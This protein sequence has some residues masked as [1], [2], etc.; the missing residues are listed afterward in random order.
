MAGIITYA[1]EKNSGLTAA[2]KNS[3]WYHPVLLFNEIGK[4]GNFTKPLRYKI[5]KTDVQILFHGYFQVSHLTVDQELKKRWRKIIRQVEKGQEPICYETDLIFL[6][7][8]YYCL[9]AKTNNESGKRVRIRRFIPWPQSKDKVLA[10]AIEMLKNRHDRG[11]YFLG[12][13]V[14]L[15]VPTGNSYSYL[16]EQEMPFD[17]CGDAIHKLTLCPD[18][19]EFKT[20]QGQDWA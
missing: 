18:R 2:R 12:D 10:R 7:Q 13:C 19:C 3:V 4:D 15:W 20:Y 14:R 1:V 8:L 5:E 9:Y 6:R 17:G 16:Y 11:R